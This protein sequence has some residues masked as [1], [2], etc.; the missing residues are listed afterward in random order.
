MAHYDNTGT[1]VADV[2]VGEDEFGIWVAGAI[3]PGATPSQVEAL[4]RSSLSGDW[5]RIGG[6]LELVAALSVNTPGFPL[7]VVASGRVE[8]LVASGASIMAALRAPD[9]EEPNPLAVYDRALRPMLDASKA[10]ARHRLG[11]LEA[12]RARERFQRIRI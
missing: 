1:A 9:L 2:A 8:A 3:R 11:T 12:Q 5:R 4:S 6:N 7:A 10:H